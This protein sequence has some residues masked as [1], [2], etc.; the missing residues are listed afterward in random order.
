MPT[1]SRYLI[2]GLQWKRICPDQVDF[3]P[4][5]FDTVQGIETHS[6][7]LPCHRLFGSEL[8]HNSAI[9]WPRLMISDRGTPTSSLSCRGTQFT[10]RDT[11]SYERYS[12]VPN[13]KLL[14]TGIHGCRPS[15]D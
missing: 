6:F 9:M 3:F 14:K 15:H 8:E 7:I 2:G 5:I 4:L 1:Y 11:L 10:F 13:V 12:H